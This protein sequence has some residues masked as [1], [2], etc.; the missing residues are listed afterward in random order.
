MLPS[1][2]RPIPLAIFGPFLRLGFFAWG[3]PVAQMAMIQRK[4]VEDVWKS[5]LNVLAV[6]VGIA[7]PGALFLDES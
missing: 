7:L 5:K 6:V 1:A 4:L 2:D 3:G